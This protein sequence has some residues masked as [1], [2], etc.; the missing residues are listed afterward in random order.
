VNSNSL[1][2]SSLLLVLAVI[3][4]S[5][6]RSE[7]ECPLNLKPDERIVYGAGISPYVRKV[8]VILHE[9]NIPYTHKDIIHAKGLRATGQ[10]IPAD[11]KEA[12]P[13]GK[14]PAYREKNWTIADSGVIAQ[15]LEQTYP[16]PI[17]FPEEP[18]KYAETLWFEKYADDVLGPVIVSIFRERV[19]KPQLLKQETDNKIVEESLKQLPALF[20]YLEKSLGTKEWIAANQFTVA[21]IALASQIVNLQAA[22]EKIDA[23]KWPHFAAYIDKILKRDSFK[24]AS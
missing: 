20:D 18:K 12:S 2:S 22:G 7:Q 24:K 13:L 17:L 14:I 23:A 4:T 6:N 1:I 11:F 21:D 8:R 5:C 19:A 16:K 10:P 3:T 15:Y 9:K